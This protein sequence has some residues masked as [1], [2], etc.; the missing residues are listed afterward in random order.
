MAVSVLV[1]AFL[2]QANIACSVTAAITQPIV[3]SFAERPLP[4]NSRTIEW[5]G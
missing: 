5:G 2:R 3:G 4:G 1:Q